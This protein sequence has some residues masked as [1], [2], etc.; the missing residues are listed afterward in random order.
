ML[1]GP[2]T[3][4]RV[5][6]LGPDMISSMRD[7]DVTGPVFG[8]LIDF[9]NRLD[10]AG[11]FYRLGHT[12]PES[13]MVEVALPGWHWEVEFMMNGS[14]EIERYQ[15]TGSIEEDPGMLE[16]IFTDIDQD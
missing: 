3:A 6:A 16:E 1:A 12:R 10:S 2:V 13:V 14:V 4:R 8:R 5:R 11:V 7:D 9:L 15:S